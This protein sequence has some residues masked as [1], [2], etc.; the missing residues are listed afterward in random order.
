MLER[1]LNT[2]GLFAGM[3]VGVLMM[4]LLFHE[5][6]FGAP[7]RPD[8]YPDGMRPPRSVRPEVSSEVQNSATPR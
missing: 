5:K 3:I 1:F 4:V 2:W 7:D 6:I 8:L